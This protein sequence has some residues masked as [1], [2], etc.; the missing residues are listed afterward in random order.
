MNTAISLK[1]TILFILAMVMFGLPSCSK[2]N[3]EPD[4]NGGN[5]GKGDPRFVGTWFSGSI[6]GGRY[7]T[8][9]GRYEGAAGM[10]MIYY[11]KADGTFSQMIVWNN[12][13]GGT[14]A[15]STT[16]KYAVKDDVI[17]YTKQVSEQSTDEGKTWK[18]KKS[19][20]DQSDYF[21]FGTDILGDYVLLS[22]DGATPPL[23]PE[24]NAAKYRFA[25]RD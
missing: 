11:F 9:T 22:L 17:T 18:D 3:D 21:E 6:S 2:D 25:G 16:G 5:T 23:N 15:A 7:N 1:R 14:W 20:S 4:D 24:T 19:Q 8:V 10:G 13:Y 12:P